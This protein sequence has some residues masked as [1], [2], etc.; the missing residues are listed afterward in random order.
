MFGEDGVGG[1]CRSEDGDESDPVP[2]EC[3]QVWGCW[4]LAIGLWVLVL[5]TERGCSDVVE[6]DPR[7]SLNIY[8]S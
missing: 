2:G 7:M 3:Q 5:T 8:N 4:L 1:E 6:L